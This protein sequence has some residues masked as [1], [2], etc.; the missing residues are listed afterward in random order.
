VADA[1]RRGQAAVERSAALVRDLLD[2]TRI[3]IGGGLPL[4]LTETPLRPIVDEVVNE[5]RL[6]HPRRTIEVS[7]SDIAAL[8]DPERVIQVV[9]N[10]LG[11]AVQHSPA[12]SPV[13]LSLAESSGYAVISI[14]N[15]GPPIPP[16]LGARLFEP[17]ERARL[18]KEDGS[19]SVGLGLYIV[20]EIVA[21]HGGSIDFASTADSGT[22]FRV[23]LPRG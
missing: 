8:A 7:G 15:L 18:R 4:E 3:R 19:R 11:N 22:T 20:R 6:A 13:A 21:A 9:G 23:R 2:L 5:M 10:L 12:V 16:A 14:H 1:A 17:L